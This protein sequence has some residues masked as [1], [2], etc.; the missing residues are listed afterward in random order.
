MPNFVASKFDFVFERLHS[1]L[2]G[3]SLCKLFVGVY[4]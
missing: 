2:A 3:F 1:S 4:A